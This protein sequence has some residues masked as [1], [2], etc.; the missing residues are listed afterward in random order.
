MRSVAGGYVVDALTATAASEPAVEAVWSIATSLLSDL[1]VAMIGYGVAIVLGAWLAGKGAIATAVRRSITP[2]I[3]DRRTLYPILLA[4]VVLVYA[5]SPTE[6]TRR[7]IPS[8]ILIALLVAG[9]EALRHQAIR[10]FPAATMEAWSQGWRD[11]VER[12]REGTQARIAARRAAHAGG[13]APAAPAAPSDRI[14]QLERLAELHSAGV[15]NDEELAE[16]K[17]LIRG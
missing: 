2:F 11:R 15:L 1:G 3:R 12:V 17:A 5:W 8:L 10:E 9:A 4:I 14:S 7:L 13:P 16:E 6:G